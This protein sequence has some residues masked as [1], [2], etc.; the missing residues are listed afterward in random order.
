[1]RVQKTF[2]HTAKTMKHGTFQ[3]R[4]TVHVC[5][6]ECRHPSGALVTRRARSI[7][8][9]IIAGTT[10]GYDTMVFIGLQR[11]LHHR[12]RE[13]IRS[14]LLHEHGIDLSSGEVS[15]LAKHF[16]QYLETLH[17]SHTG[18]IRETFASEG[19]YPL[20]VDATGEDGRGTLL[21]AL[22]GWRRW[23]LDAWKIPTEHTEV[24]LPALRSVAKRFGA[25][26]A[27]VR[28]LGRAMIPA[29]D[30]LVSE[31][32]GEIRVLS[33]HQHFLADVGKDLIDPGHGELRNLFR[34]YKIRPNL[35]S[36]ARDL[37]RKLGVD[38]AKAREEVVVWQA[39]LDEGH[40]VPT[41]RVGHASVR[42]VAQWV[43]D[44]PAD[45]NDQGF[46]FDRP[47][48][49]LYQRC[50]TAR[51]AV[52]AFLRTPPNDK[53]VRGTLERL[54]R[55][56]EPVLAEPS[57]HLVA[58]RLR[59]RARLFDVLRD[60]LRLFPKSGGRNT[61]PDAQSLHLNEAIEE[62]HDIQAA[63]E[64]F[65]A[66]LRE[67]RPGRGPAQ[68]MRAAIDI[69]L[70][71]IETHGDTLWGHVVSLST[72]EGEI[73][74]IVD[75]TN[76]NL[77]RGL[78][79]ELKQGERRRSGRKNLTQDFEHLPAAVALTSNLT[80]PDYVELVCG[81]LDQLPEVFAALDAERRERKSAGQSPPPLG[82]SFD[83]IPEVATAS[84]PKADRPLLRSEA[85]QR[86]VLAAANSRAPRIPVKRLGRIA[87]TA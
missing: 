37:G 71:H 17:E 27:L 63:V 73:I 61:T 78:F 87:A 69:I 25:P 56:L 8:K 58:D 76:N 26:C 30:A 36:L 43:L 15:N 14:D 80:R 85:M 57:F 23:V 74:R 75:R 65:V 41:G 4:E 50:V 18:R 19:G 28:D 44:Y 64:S 16:L 77:E 24:I 79:G 84:L 86:R 51:R 62:L 38:I 11:Y 42:A 39:R 29:V 40:V 22:A 5:R 1:M 9:H 7:T 48:L 46:P 66:W 49:N 6:A 59:E 83:P 70:Q 3:V 67:R 52:D 45:G 47:Y 33:C 10:I 12:Q 21:V 31:T 32:D 53:Q 34:R 13:E 55:I 81:T 54:A 35:G 60:A 82:R 2:L 68:D 20:H 72:P